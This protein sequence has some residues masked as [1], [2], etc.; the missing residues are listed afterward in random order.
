MIGHERIDLLKKP[1]SI[2]INTIKQIAIQLWTEPHVM[3][4]ATNDKTEAFA[5]CVFTK[6]LLSTLD[7][8]FKHSILSCIGDS[9]SLF[10]NDGPLIYTLVISKL[11]P[12]E[13]LFFNELRTNASHLKSAKFMDFQIFLKTLFETMQSCS[14]ANQAALLLVVLHSI[15]EQTNPLL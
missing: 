15:N 12:Q 5:C 6:L 10:A 11:F 9:N 2:N 4:K 14:Q 1:F 8:D 7:P 3:S 13:S